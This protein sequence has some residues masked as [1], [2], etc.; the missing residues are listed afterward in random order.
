M[1]VSRL[2]TLLLAVLLAA[3]AALAAQSESGHVYQLNVFRANSGMEA[4]YSQS[5]HEYLRP[6]WSEIVR[7][8][9]M[10]SF[11][12]LWK[13]AG[14]L[15]TGTHMILLEFE[16]WD[17]YASFGASAERASRSV[18]GRPWADISAQEFVPLRQ[19]LRTEVYAAPPSG[20]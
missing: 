17:D 12:D 11:V 5:Y 20:M 15:T 7:N 18:T 1:R 6:I 14:D 3:P 16:S 19:I 13:Q 10:V 9:D 2:G 4:A 8:G